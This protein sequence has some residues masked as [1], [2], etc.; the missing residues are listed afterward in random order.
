[1]KCDRQFGVPNFSLLDYF[2][3]GMAVWSSTLKHTV[4]ANTIPATPGPI[5]SD[6]KVKCKKTENKGYR[7]HK[8]L[9]IKLHVTEVRF[10][11]MAIYQSTKDTITPTPGSIP[12]G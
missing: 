10:F 9:L 6:G 12:S 4:K 3:V 8:L 11:G 1:M 5:P 2:L 7:I